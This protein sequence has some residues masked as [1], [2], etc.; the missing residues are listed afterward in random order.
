MRSGILRVLAVF[1]LA[2]V[3][4]GGCER[5]FQ[6]FLE[7]SKDPFW[8]FGYLDLEADTQWVRVM[9][10]RQSVLTEPGPIDAVVTLEKVGSGRVVE[11]KDSLFS[12]EDPN[13]QAVR[14]AH[15]FWTT[16]PLEPNTRYVLRAAQSDGSVSVAT[17][18]M[19]AAVEFTFL[20]LESSH[21][22]AYVEIH[23]ER[24]L[25]EDVIH[26]MKN[27]ADDPAGSVVVRQPK[28]F[29][30]GAPGT[31][32][33]YP[34]GV[35]VER[36]GLRDV[37]R[38]E[39]RI[40]TARA[41][42][43]FDPGLSD[44]DITVPGKMPTNIE[45]GVGYVGG[46]A[47][48]TVPFNRCSVLSPR[49]AGLQS[50]VLSFNTRSAS[51]SGQVSRTPCGEPHALAEI[52]LVE[53]FPDGGSIS[54]RWKTDWNGRY[55]FEGLEPGTDLILILGPGTSPVHLPSLAPGQRYIVQDLTVPFDC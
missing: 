29:A 7:S 46:V 16:E 32:A 39:L 28:P 18:D 22:T 25:F 23:G 47:N 9:P 8:I 35:P 45:N 1:L 55:R 10:V 52:R 17:I 53:S 4:G 49:A 19:P 27:S 41:D 14:Y 36:V 30:T 43:P 13:L 24:V 3:V 21:D 42:W 54:L 20:N 26:A 48:W 31:F 40:A 11:L 38:T 50:C 34:I 37:G 2:G 12:F 33:S 15:N 44:L 6:P 5:P 51:I